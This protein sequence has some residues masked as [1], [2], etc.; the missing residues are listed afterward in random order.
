MTN[1]RVVR[2]G[3]DLVEALQL[4]EYA[5]HLRQYGERAPGGNETWR[6]FDTRA[7]EFLR[8]LSGPARVAY[9]RQVLGPSLTSPA[10]PYRV[11][12]EPQRYVPPSGMEAE[13]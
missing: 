4:I 9:A 1:E 13:R 8:R 10:D 3:G 6:E 7:E 2:L 12:D 5:L 11:T